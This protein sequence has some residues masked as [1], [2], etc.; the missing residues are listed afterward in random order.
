MFVSS[1]VC[2]SAS[3]GDLF[4]YVVGILKLMQQLSLFFYLVVF[5]QYNSS[6]LATCLSVHSDFA[7][8]SLV[9]PARLLLR[10]TLKGT[11]HIALM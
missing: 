10:Y 9:V 1:Y 5:V 8:S 7:L 3:V 4:N 2:I 11:E 6:V